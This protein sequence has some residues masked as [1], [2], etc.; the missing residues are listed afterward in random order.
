MVSRIHLLCLLAMQEGKRSMAN[1]DFQAL[2]DF[3]W[4]TPLAQIQRILWP[5]ACQRCNFCRCWT[6]RRMQH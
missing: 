6:E 5:I 3:A 4:A 2:A 1:P